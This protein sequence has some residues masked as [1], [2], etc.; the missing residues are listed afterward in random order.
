MNAPF[1]GIDSD[2]QGF[3]YKS[4]VTEQIKQY[5]KIFALGEFGLLEIGVVGTSKDNA[6]IYGEIPVYFATVDMLHMAGS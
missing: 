5:M 2:H 3:C 6:N 4:D 1:A